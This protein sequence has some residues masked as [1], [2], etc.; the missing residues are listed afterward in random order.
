M[1]DTAVTRPLPTA[2]VEATRDIPFYRDC[3]AANSYPII[4]KADLAESFPASFMTPEV[5]EALE[6]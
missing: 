3:A 6:T 4:T 2:F 1:T 5:T